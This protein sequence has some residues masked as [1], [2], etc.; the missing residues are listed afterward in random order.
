MPSRRRRKVRVYSR[1]VLV[2]LSAFKGTLILFLI[3]VIAGSILLRL[4]YPLGFL[5]SIYQAVT[6]MFFASTLPYP[7]GYPFYQII[8]IVFPLFG[9]LMLAQ[10]LEG[11]GSAIKFGD[12]TSE[13]WNQEVTKILENHIIVTGIGNLGVRVV[14]DLVQKGQDIVMID[15]VP[16]DVKRSLIEHYQKS[17]RIPLVEGD[18]RLEHVLLQ[19]GLE[20]AQAIMLLIDDDLTNLKIATKVRKIRPKIKLILRMFDL[21]FGEEM[22]KIMKFSLFS[23]TKIAVDHFIQDLDLKKSVERPNEA[24]TA[25]EEYDV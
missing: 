11:I 3:G 22:S 14:E 24:S 13:E 21:E 9:L 8:W 5:E 4:R 18:S 12:T 19:A 6:L 15:L 7:T 20:R 10:S 17:Y 1:E 23:T 25:P 16:D 2:R